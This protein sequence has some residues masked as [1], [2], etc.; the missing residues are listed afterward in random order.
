MTTGP[1]FPQVFK[2]A[3]EVDLARQAELDAIGA[4]AAEARLAIVDMT[5]ITFVDSTVVTWLLRTKEV[6]EQKNGNLR[7]VAP[8]GLVTQLLAMS[9]LEGVIEVL[10]TLPEA[11]AAMSGEE[12]L[13]G[14]PGL[15]G[16]IANQSEASNGLVHPV[17]VPNSPT[18]Q[19]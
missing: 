14:W 9:K 7:V 2:L 16:P 1:T 19:T 10:P 5:E 8:Q 11:I 13:G 6:L 17:L 4:A 15:H 3:G 12:V 18:P